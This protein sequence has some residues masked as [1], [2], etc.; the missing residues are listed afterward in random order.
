MDEPEIVTELLAIMENG[1]EPMQLHGLMALAHKDGAQIERCIDAAGRKSRRRQRA[2][3]VHALLR[4]NDLMNQYERLP[5]KS[6]KKRVKVTM[7]SVR[8]EMIIR[9]G[10]GE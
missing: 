10:L 3:E 6:S 8:R 7:N 4:L 1:C 5:K 2:L 9:R